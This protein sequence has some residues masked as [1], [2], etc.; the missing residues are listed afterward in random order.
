MVVLQQLEAFYDNLPKQYA[1]DDLNIYLL[2]DQHMLGA[3]FFLHLLY[4][5][6]ICDL[7]RTSLPGFDFPL[8]AA[9]RDAPASFITQC[10]Q[11]CYFHA[12]SISQIIRKGL[13]HGRIAFGDP[14]VADATFESTK[15]QIVYAA[16]L[17]H[18]PDAIKLTTINLQTNIKLLDTLSSNESGGSY[19]VSDPAPLT[20]CEQAS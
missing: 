4:Q 16:T 14:F 3:V 5:A 11:R 1:L 6:A 18:D 7:C 10:Q 20:V 15:I 17:R 13:R 12:E 2:K 19:H 8:A 9:F